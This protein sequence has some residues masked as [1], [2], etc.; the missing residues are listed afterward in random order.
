MAEQPYYGKVNDILSQG[1]GTSPEVGPPPPS[2][3]L[4]IGR[5][6]RRAAVW[7]VV[8]LCFVYL[9]DWAQASYRI[10]RNGGLSTVNIDRYSVIHQKNNRMEFNYLDSEPQRCVQS[11]FPHADYEPCWYLRRHREQRTDY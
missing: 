10:D 9:A 2:R 8:V 7:A 11:L 5:W 1:S 6:L 4:P 3:L